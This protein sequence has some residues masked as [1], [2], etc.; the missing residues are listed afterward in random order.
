MYARVLKKADQVRTF[1]ITST[2]DAGWEVREEQDSRTVRAVRYTD[3]HRVERAKLAF[4]QQ[5]LDLRNAGWIE[6]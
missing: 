6:A 2:A 5:A 4:A 1:T 3:W